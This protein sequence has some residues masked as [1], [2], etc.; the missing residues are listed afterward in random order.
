M[1]GFYIPKSL[2]D[3]FVTLNKILPDS[4]KNE[5][6]LMEE[7]EAVSRSHFGL[8]IWM[9]NNWGLWGG[10]R[11]SIY[12]NELGVYHPDDMSGIILTSYHRYL[13]SKELKLEDQIKYYQK[14]WEEINKQEEETEKKI[15]LKIEKNL[16]WLKDNNIELNVL[17]KENQK[18]ILYSC[19]STLIVKKI[20]GDTLIYWTFSMQ[21]SLDT[22][23]VKEMITSKFFGKTQYIKG[24]NYQGNIS[25]VTLHPKVFL[26]RNDSLFEKETFYK[27]SRDSISVLYSNMYNPV[28]DTIKTELNR[29]IIKENTYQDFKLIFHPNLFDNRISY[30]ENKNNDQIYLTS[31][32]KLDDQIYYQIK[33]ENNMGRS[34]T[35]YSYLFDKN[36]RFL[37]YDGCNEEELNQLV[38]SDK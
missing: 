1:N 7:N 6:E 23:E 12:F 18:D 32:W 38:E 16:R 11:L 9:R 4:I 22:T 36:Y 15:R 17:P 24:V 26:I 20:R 5:F 13:N 14:Y 31:T 30:D 37:K 29:S 33:V 10:T 34:K 3:C 2:D 28:E 8:G 35:E 25:Y 27:I 21:S 19:D